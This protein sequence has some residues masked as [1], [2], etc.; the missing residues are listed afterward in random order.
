MPSAPHALPFFPSSLSPSLPTHMHVST[1]THSHA[2]AV[3]SRIPSSRLLAGFCGWSPPKERGLQIPL[4]EPRAPA[5]DSGAF[6]FPC[7][8]PG[9]LPWTLA[10]SGSPAG[11]PDR[12]PRLWNLRVPLWEPRSPALDSGVFGFPF[13]SP[14]PLP[15]ALASSGSP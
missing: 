9:P 6:G 3:P 11:T 7:G 15:W 10:S 14:R 13:G 4:R 5:L 1:H 8:S 12:S 2:H